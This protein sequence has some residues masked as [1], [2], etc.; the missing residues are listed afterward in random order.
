LVVCAVD[1]MLGDQARGEQS[2]DG[3]VDELCGFTPHLDVPTTVA[4]A[5]LEVPDV[6]HLD[7]GRWRCDRGR[8]F[9]RRFGL[10]ASIS[11]QKDSLEPL[12]CL[13]G[14]SVPLATSWPKGRPACARRVFGPTTARPVVMA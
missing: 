6:D 12:S 3:G 9:D 7:Q 10:V 5:D 4:V 14:H 8:G 2:I 13:H 1:L 11:G